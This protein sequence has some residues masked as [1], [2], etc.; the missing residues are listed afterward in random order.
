MIQ[1]A[2]KEGAIVIQ[3][4]EKYIIKVKTML[5]DSS[6]YKRLMLD[7]MLIRSLEEKWM[8]SNV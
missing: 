4:T 2:D 6:C 8:N 1:R 7:Q 3:N 5:S